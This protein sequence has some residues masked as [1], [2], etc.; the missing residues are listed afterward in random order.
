MQTF[1]VGKVDR[2]PVALS[3]NGVVRPA[4][5]GDPTVREEYIDRPWGSLTP[6]TKLPMLESTTPINYVTSRNCTK[7]SAAL[8]DTF[9]P[10]RTN[11]L[12]RTE[13]NPPI[14]SFISPLV[15]EKI[16][17]FLQKSM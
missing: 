17:T 7:L 15:T 13:K 8:I 10:I 4:G 2:V 14:K 16:L 3:F 9:Q 12:R 1:F 5:H 6:A 11:E